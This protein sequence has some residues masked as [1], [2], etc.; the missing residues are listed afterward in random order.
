ML[1]VGSLSLKAQCINMETLDAPGTRCAVANHEFERLDATKY[2]YAWKWYENQ[3]EDYGLTGYNRSYGVDNLLCTRQTVVKTAGQDYLQPSLSMLPP[4]KS[5]S[6]RLGNPRAGGRGTPQVNPTQYATWHLQAEAVSFDITVTP[7]NAL[8]LFRYAAIMDRPSHPLTGS[9]PNASPYFEVGLVNR[10]T[11]VL[12]EEDLLNKSTAYFCRSGDSDIANN[13][14][15][16]RFARTGF[17]NCYWKDW[18]TVGFDLT[19]YMGQTI[20]LRVENYDC[21]LASASTTN[22]TYC[23]DHFGYMYLYAECAKKEI[24]VECMEGRQVQLTAPEGFNYSWYEVGKPSVVLGTGR[25]LT[26]TADGKTKYGCKLTQREGMTGSFV[27]EVQPQCAITKYIYET[28]CEKDL[29]RVFNGRKL[30]ESGTYEHTVTLPS[31]I[32]SVTYY[33][34]TVQKAANARIESASFCEG[35]NYTWTGHGARFAALNKPGIYKDTLRYP[36]G[37]DSLR[38]ELHLERQEQVKKTETYNLCKEYFEGGNGFKWHGVDVSGFEFNGKK[39]TVPA[40]EGCDTLFT[41]ELKTVETVVTHDTVI[42]EKYGFTWRGYTINETLATLFENTGLSINDGNCK[43][44]IYLHT[45]IAKKET[46]TVN[47]CNNELP[48][49]WRGQNIRGMQ[50]NGKRVAGKDIHGKDSVYYTLALT[51]RQTSAAEIYRTICHGEKFDFGDKRLDKEGVY[52]RTTTNAAGCDSVI[53]LHLKVTDPPVEVTTDDGICTGETYVWE[54]HEKRYPALKQRGIYRDTARYASGCDSAH[55]TLN[56]EVYYP[57]YADLY[58]TIC[59]GDSV[60]Y[61]DTVLYTTGTY[62]RTTLNYAGCDS[63]I[64]LHLKVHEPTYSETKRYVC[65]GD[66]FSWEGHGEKFAK[67][68]PGIYKDT[69]TGMHGCDSITTLQLMLSKNIQTSVEERLCKGDKLMFADSAI[70]DGGTYT[71]TFKR[72]GLCDSIVTL[73]VTEIYPTD[74]VINAAICEGGSYMFF[75]QELKTGGK[76]SRTLT[77]AAGCDSVVTLNLKLNQ[78]SYTLIEDTI[79]EGGS[80]TF[81]GQELKNRGKYSQTLTNAAGCDSVVTLQLETAPTYNKELTASICEGGTC[82]VFSDTML[83]TQGDYTRHYKT[84]AGCDSA[85]TVHLTVG[86]EVVYPLEGRFC[87]GGTYVFADSVI[88]DAGTYSH[89]FVRE[90]KCDS[91]VVL[92]LTMDSA[93]VYYDTATI[94]PGGSYTL[95]TRQLSVPGTWRD[96]VYE[97]VTHCMSVTSLT[98][99]VVEKDTVLRDTVVVCDGGQYTWEGHKGFE[100]L[101]TSGLYVDSTLSKVHYELVLVISP[102]PIDIEDSAVISSEEPYSWRHHAGFDNLT[103]SGT[104]FDTLRYA[105]GCDSARYTLH[106]EVYSPIVEADVS[107]DTVC[108]NDHA[109]ALRLKTKSGMPVSCDVL[110]GEAAHAQRFRDTLGIELKEGAQETLLAIDIPAGKDSADYVRPDTY[111][112]TV[113]LT[114]IFGHETLFDGKLHVLYPAWVLVQRWNDVL[115][116]SNEHYNGGYTFSAVRWFHAGTEIEARG[117]HDGYIYQ[118]PSL[119]MGEPYWAEL[120][121][122]DDGRTVRTCVIYPSPQTDET[123]PAGIEVTLTPRNNDHRRISVASNCSGTY[124]VYDVAGRMLGS[125]RFGEDYGSPDI[126]LPHAMADGTYLLAFKADDGRTVVRKWIVH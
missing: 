17:S 97:D 67:L 18:T 105:S 61:F 62:R 99:Y 15:W 126:Q 98:L 76:Y 68:T 95:G 122:T 96:T 55:Y 115:M 57:S 72:E 64:S 39:V 37:C 49:T 4:G 124:T 80:Y 7:D 79:C 36:G 69:L 65:E 121:R 111:D 43:E 85:V 108:A 118:R 23:K 74:S 3:R 42:E 34:L 25:I 47:C 6:I 73:T 24:E 16:R 13:P 20:R 123:V 60:I 125:G 41:L 48:L 83:T 38:C 63:V 58:D 90:D 2:W 103:Q 31:G 119:E 109:F 30:T 78:L 8:L 117:E 19:P 12:K 120:T 46:E 112:Y 40:S 35:T 1:L 114:D 91:I 88:R 71:H 14:E 77:N 21:I 26:V 53:T 92:K 54:G 104:Y 116:L 28:V 106:L 84:I 9:N 87:E 32:D 89:T 94:F 100:N 27:L 59:K 75:G 93:H 81:F 101:T 44:K 107:T 86:S 102:R 45:I 82:T 50:D 33:V 5:T 22:F 56:L 66:F 113:R 51:V 70:Y 29:P 52:T 10:N 11:Y 110:F